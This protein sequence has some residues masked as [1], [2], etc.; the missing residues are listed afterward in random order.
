MRRSGPGRLR[1]VVAQLQGVALP[2]SAMVDEILPSR[3]LGFSYDQL[4]HLGAMGEVVWVGR[5]P[6]G[7]RDGK[8]ALYRRDQVPVLVNVPAVPDG[9]LDDPEDRAAV[10]RAALYTHLSDRGA[11]FASQLQAAAGNPSLTDF[12]DA[13]WDL[14]WAG[15]VTNDT[16]QP[17]RA[18]RARSRRGTRAAGARVA[19]GRWST[20]AE[21]VGAGAGDTEKLYARA[22]TLLE[23]HGI[24]GRTAV[25]S[26]GIDGGFSGVYPLFRAM[27]ESGR[28]R[29]GH[30]V[31]GAGGAQFALPGAVDRLRDCRR[32]DEVVIVLSAVDPANPWGATLPWPE[33]AGSPRR[34]AGGVVVLVG[35]RPV[36]FVE[37]QAVLSFPA[38]RDEP[39]LDAAVAGWCAGRRIRVE[40]IDREDATASALAGAFFRAGFA[41]DYRCLEH[42]G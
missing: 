36:L 21:L 22:T 25:L 42:V 37:G 4:D 7:G 3:V 10:L 11:S 1:E 23:R 40:L 13:L 30:F 27:E 12:A 28:A 2:W 26:E 39:V 5:S 34:A 9:L 18:L 19:G 31:D 32:Q 35:G 15:L 20:V 24:V 29:R 38:A 8:V 16:F 33:S 17:L 6:L 14:V 41:E